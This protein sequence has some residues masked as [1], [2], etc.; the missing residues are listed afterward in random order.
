MTIHGS[1]IRATLIRATLIRATLNGRGQ[2]TC[3]IDRL[4]T[5]CD[6]AV[7]LFIANRLQDPAELARL[8]R[9][10]RNSNRPGL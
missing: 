1:E 6:L 8:F 4:F 7:Q 2:C 9:K 10:N 5:S 3:S